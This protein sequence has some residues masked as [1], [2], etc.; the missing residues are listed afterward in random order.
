MLFM[1][2]IKFIGLFGTVL[3]IQ[4][5][6]IIIFIVSTVYLGNQQVAGLIG[7]ISSMIMA[8]VLIATLLKNDR[9][10]S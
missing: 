7:N 2:F 5:I 3:G 4:M 6:A 8:L 9:L 1:D 10:M